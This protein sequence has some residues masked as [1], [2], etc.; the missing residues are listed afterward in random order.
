MLYLL[1]LAAEVP[2][3]NGGLTVTEPKPLS[4]PLASASTAGTT[5]VVPKVIESILVV[6]NEKADDVVVGDT[7][8]RRLKRTVEEE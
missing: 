8:R 1:G 6:D 7:K 3:G 4:L 5:I 2:I